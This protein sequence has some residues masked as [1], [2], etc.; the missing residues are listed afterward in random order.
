MLAELRPDAGLQVAAALAAHTAAATAGMQPQFMVAAQ[1][2]GVSMHP[3][4]AVAAGDGRAVPTAPLVS[5]SSSCKLGLR[6]LGQP[7]SL[8]QVASQHFCCCPGSPEIT[9]PWLQLLARFHALADT[10]AAQSKETWHYN[11]ESV[12]KEDPRLEQGPNALPGAVS[13]THRPED[14]LAAMAV[15][16]LSNGPVYMPTLVQHLQQGVGIAFDD[17]ER[18]PTAA[19]PLTTPATQL[20]QA[21]QMRLTQQQQPSRRGLVGAAGATAE[22]QGALP[23]PPVGDELS[24]LFCWLHAD[25]LAQVQPCD[26]Q[27]H[28]AVQVS[29]SSSKD[30]LLAADQACDWCCGALQQQQQQQRSA[31]A[32]GGVKGGHCSSSSSSSKQWGCSSCGSAQ[33][34]SQ[35]CADAAKKVHN[36]NCW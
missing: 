36:D 18:V 25:R 16:L 31:R 19:A 6:S 3:A 23:R 35:H 20:V 17:C 7:L 32:A 27:Q 11:L 30:V 24:G 15:A 33:Y 13:G 8:F 9:L 1:R 2:A 28:L 26:W 21:L 12:D 14:R 4:A 34:C 22:Q 29:S 5:S 10:F